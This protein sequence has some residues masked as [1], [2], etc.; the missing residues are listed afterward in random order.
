MTHQARI[1][2]LA[3]SIFKARSTLVPA[4]IWPTLMVRSEGAEVNSLLQEWG[5]PDLGVEPVISL[6]ISARERTGRLLIAPKSAAMIKTKAQAW[7]ISSE[8]NLFPAIDITGHWTRYDPVHSAVSRLLGQQTIPNILSHLSDPLMALPPQLNPLGP[9]V[10]V[11][12]I[13]NTAPLHL[14]PRESKTHQF[15]VN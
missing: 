4:T 5:A 12:A 10:G 14:N 15:S 6:L 13:S 1:K 8:S 9:G 3:S 11:A 7:N 2:T